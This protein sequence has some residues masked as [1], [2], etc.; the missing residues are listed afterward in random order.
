MVEDL[1]PLSTTCYSLFVN[2]QS[3]SAHYHEYQKMLT[4]LV[5][6][7]VE[8]YQRPFENL[9]RLYQQNNRYKDDELNNLHLNSL[10]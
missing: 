3:T 6:V 9:S 4:W 7:D 8:Q 2:F 5:D 1:W 10:H